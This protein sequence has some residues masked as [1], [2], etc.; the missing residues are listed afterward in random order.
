[1]AAWADSHSARLSLITMTSLLLTGLAI[2]AG[3]FFLTW[4]ISVRIRNYGLLDA[5]W[6]Y[7]VAILAPFY[8]WMGPGDATRKWTLTVI[9]V[10]WS[11][12]LG[13]YILRRVI[14]HHPAEDA[15]Y[16]TLR[17]RWPGS[18]MFLLFFQLQAVLVVIFSLPF[19]LISFNLEPGLKT[20][21]VIGL[22]VALLSLGGESLAD[23]QMKAFKAD[24][25]NQ[26][27]V[28]QDGLWHYSRHPNYFFEFMIWVGFS[29][30][31]LASPWGWTTVVCPLLMLHFL[32]NVTGIKLSEEYSLK[33]KGGAYRDYQ[34]TT[35]AFVPWFRKK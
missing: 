16:Q 3:Y 22:A 17:A 21:E 4:L 13:T 23:A 9:G 34:R 29:L 8:A 35:S 6:S 7:G 25:G 14:S 28:C 30:A 1:M 33:S 18:G 19:L 12:R 31:A 2:A 5:A 27:K 26:G 20:L 32:L 24:P 11:L 10:A 15:R